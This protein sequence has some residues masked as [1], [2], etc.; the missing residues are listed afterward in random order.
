MKPVAFFQ[1]FD[2]VE[3]IVAA[4]RALGNRA[5]TRVQAVFGEDPQEGTRGCRVDF[6]VL[7][8]ASGAQRYLRR[9]GP[10]PECAVEWTAAGEALSA[11]AQQALVSELLDAIGDRIAKVHKEQSILNVQPVGKSFLLMD[12]TRFDVLA[13]DGAGQLRIRIHRPEGVSEAGLA[14]NDLLDGLYSGLIT[15]I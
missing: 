14:A 3:L 6:K 8:R 7:D 10:A 13:D 2:L 9:I 5:I 12:R 11:G 1:R 4:D 15:R